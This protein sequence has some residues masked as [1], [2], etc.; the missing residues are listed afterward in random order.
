MT[1]HDDGQRMASEEEPLPSRRHEV[2]ALYLCPVKL[3]VNAVRL[4][5]VMQRLAPV[6][7]QTI[8]KVLDPRRALRLALILCS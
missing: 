5:V 7:I 8:V 2:P 3:S 6:L 1:S 4:E